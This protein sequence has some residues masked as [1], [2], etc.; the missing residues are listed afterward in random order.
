MM[1]SSEPLV[2]VDARTD[3]SYRSD[4]RHAALAV[5]IPP[6]DPV[7]AATEQRLAQHS[8]LV[9]YCA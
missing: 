9:V 5:R 1:A 4:P 3:K 7:R 6:E 2:F 8:T